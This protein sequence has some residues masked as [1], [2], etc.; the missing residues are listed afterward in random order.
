LAAAA[1]V[2][3]RK[4]YS[5][6]R[7]ADV[8]EIAELRSPAVYYYFDSRD[9]LVAEVMVT[10]QRWLR[11]AVESA[12]AA[13][14]PRTGVAERLAIAVAT[15]LRVELTLSDF[16]SA[17][18]RNS[19][20]VPDHIRDAIAQE[21]SAYHDIWRRLLADSA[22]AGLLRPGLDTRS[23]RMLVV[24]ALNWSAEWYRNGQDRIDVVVQ[25]A[26]TMIH[27]GLLVESS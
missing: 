23:A 12:L 13:L 25:S 7:L 11:E 2:L 21:S 9:A 19:G 14:P 26:Q 17:V 8:A 3:T 18:T 5:N 1:Q 27:H 16:A 22:Q 4:G 6:T 10:G 20:Q 15:H 24:G